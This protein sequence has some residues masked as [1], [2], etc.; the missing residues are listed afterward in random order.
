MSPRFALVLWQPSLLV[1][2]ALAGCSG[3]EFESCQGADCAD[4]TTGGT[5][6]SAGENGG[7]SAGSGNSGG[8]G[9]GGG[10]TSATG[11][12]GGSEV[13]G[14]GGSENGTGGDAGLGGSSVTDMGGSTAM[15][16]ST[17]GS[18]TAGAGG[19][20]TGGGSTEPESTGVSGSRLK[21]RYL[22]AGEGATMVIDFWDSDLE[23]PCAFDESVD[24][25]F[26]CIIDSNLIG[27]VL[28]ADASCNQPVYGED[29][30]TCDTGWVRANASG[31]VYRATTTPATVEG[32]SG[33]FFVETSDGDCSELPLTPTGNYYEAEL[34][35][36][37]SFVGGDIETEERQDG[38]VTRYAVGDDGS[39]ILV[40]TWFEERGYQCAF[41]EQGYCLPTD[42][43]QPDASYFEDDAC[44]TPVSGFYGGEPPMI[45]Q[46]STSDYCPDLDFYERGVEITSGVL[47][48]LDP[49]NTCVEVTPS[50]S[51]YNFFKL[52]PK[53]SL[54][55]IPKAKRELVGG[56]MLVAR[57]W[58][59]NAGDPLTEA[60]EFWDTTR[61]EACIPF[62][63][64]SGDYVC[65]PKNYAYVDGS[66]HLDESCSDAD[67]RAYASCPSGT[68]RV[69]VRFGQPSCE[70]ANMYTVEAAYSIGA[71][72]GVDYYFE[73]AY[74]T[75]EKR[76]MPDVYSAYSTDES[77]LDGLPVLE[78]VVDE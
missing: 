61:D 75:C 43:I 6:G 33:Y 22:E 56:G 49:T 15:N 35:P 48:W 44:S 73:N 17:G 2:L 65:V 28:F 4:T 30:E 36:S 34:V 50:Y 58:V 23:I 57:R 11:G 32:D 53:I 78:L 59:D 52:G 12:A 20:S 29:R 26:R 5:S 27:D 14:A 46:K 63:M 3:D 9:S 41:D 68:P 13:V 64:G 45:S 62:A 72:L 76:S 66:E 24:S 39:R 7:G 21:R 55:T 69:G 19:S 1:G 71:P 8:G 16:T 77:L 25:N 54:S 10:S 47:Y 37:S 42:R 31:S 67:Q 60:D 38:L 51:T 74:V 70:V 40:D 18:Q